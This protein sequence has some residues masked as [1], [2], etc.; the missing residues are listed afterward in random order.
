[1]FPS[2]LPPAPLLLLPFPAHFIPCLLT[3]GAGGMGG[4]GLGNMPM[5]NMGMNSMG[6]ADGSDWSGEASECRLVSG[7]VF[8]LVACHVLALPLFL[9]ACICVSCLYL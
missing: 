8:R 4:M 2:P 1:M 6:Y 9:T 7:H 5:G 3:A